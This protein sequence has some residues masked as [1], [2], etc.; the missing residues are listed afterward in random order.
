MCQDEDED[1]N[2]DKN[3][4]FGSFWNLCMTNEPILQYILVL[5]PGSFVTGFIQSER[6]L[7]SLGSFSFSSWHMNSLYIPPDYMP[8]PFFLQVRDFCLII[9]KK[10][11]HSTTTLCTLCSLEKISDHTWSSA[12]K[13]P[14][15]YLACRL[16]H[17]TAR[18]YKCMAEH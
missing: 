10:F 16:Y 13:M 2:E 5:R 11:G 18:I 4:S 9:L 3:Q 7:L 17:A 6:K 14:K 1:E 8:L 12:W 15:R